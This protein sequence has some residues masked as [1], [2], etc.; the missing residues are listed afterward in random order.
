MDVFLMSIIKIKNWLY[1]LLINV[2]NHF[3]ICSCLK[4]F[5]EQTDHFVIWQLFS[6]MWP[7]TFE[8][9]CCQLFL[10][11]FALFVYLFAIFYNCDRINFM[12]HPSCII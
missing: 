10:P 3:K 8:L 9:S 2:K 1:I 6:R 11:L 5:I 7:D 4:I 12:R